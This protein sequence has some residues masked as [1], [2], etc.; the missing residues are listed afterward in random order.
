M[1]GSCPPGSGSEAAEAPEPPAAA[2]PSL[3][4]SAGA[5]A[6][7]RG[8]RRRPPAGPWNLNLGRKPESQLFFECQP[9]EA[10]TEGPGC[11]GRLTS[12]RQ[13]LDR[14]LIEVATAQQ[15]HREVRMPACRLD[16]DQFDR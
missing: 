4:K 2:G 14:A 9:T 16:M 10:P 5:P 13:Q 15:R 11:P 3:S 1:V 6:P 7:A 12:T 8:R